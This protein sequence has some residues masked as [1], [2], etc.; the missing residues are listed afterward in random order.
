MPEAI[1]LMAY[2]SLC[3]DELC[4]GVVLT[5]VNTLWILSDVLIHNDSHSNKSTA[6]QLG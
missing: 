4:I 1:F 2:T 6:E 5:S 3:S